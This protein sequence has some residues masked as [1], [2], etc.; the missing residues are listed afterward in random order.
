[1]LSRKCPGVI[2][3]NSA[4]TVVEHCR[5]HHRS[6]LTDLDLRNEA[7]SSGPSLPTLRI[8]GPTCPT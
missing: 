1:M 3:C 2:Q 4:G 6:D 8:I 5:A 7:F